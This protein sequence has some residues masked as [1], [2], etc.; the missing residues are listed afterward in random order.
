[1]R[2]KYNICP[3]NGQDIYDYLTKLLQTLYSANLPSITAQLK[4]TQN[5]LLNNNTKSLKVLANT[6]HSLN[7][8]L[9][10]GCPWFTPI[11]VKHIF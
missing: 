3:F 9:C 6:T 5:N 4:H 10:I 1:M 8:S 7:L 2:N 11:K